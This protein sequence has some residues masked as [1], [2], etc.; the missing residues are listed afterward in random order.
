MAAPK[1]NNFQK[2]SKGGGDVKGRLELF[3]K[4]NRFGGATRPLWIVWG[5]NQPKGPMGSPRRPPWP[6]TLGAT[7]DLIGS[8]RSP[9]LPQQ[10]SNVDVDPKGHVRPPPLTLRDRTP[11]HAPLANKRQPYV[12][13]ILW[14]AIK[15]QLADPL[16]AMTRIYIFAT[17]LKPSVFCRGSKALEVEEV[18]SPFALVVVCHEE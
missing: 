10:S 3:W 5:P 2:S 13:I 11:P 16:W 9:V 7:L 15:D 4:F 1:R 6:P 17:H 14:V 8:L 18:A 12:V